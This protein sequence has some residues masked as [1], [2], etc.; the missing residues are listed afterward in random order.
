MSCFIYPSCPT[1][2][3]TLHLPCICMTPHLCPWILLPTVPFPLLLC[4]LSI[5]LQDSAEELFLLR[6]LSALRAPYALFWQKTFKCSNYL[7]T[8]HLLHQT[9][10]SLKIDTL[11]NSFI[12]QYL[13]QYLTLRKLLTNI[14]FLN[15]SLSH[16]IQL[17]QALYKVLRP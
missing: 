16:I 10:G 3:T 17:G 14:H 8:S 5:I 13:A 15:K 2:Q 9:Q 7:F 1:S 4:L 11:S 6:H 12:S